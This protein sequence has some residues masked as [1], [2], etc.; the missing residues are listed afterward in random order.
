M[1]ANAEI[2]APH[3]EP[4]LKQFQA[5]VKDVHGSKETVLAHAVSAVGASQIV[6]FFMP[7]RMLVQLTRMTDT[8]PAKLAAP[9]WSGPALDG[10]Y[11][12]KLKGDC[13]DPLGGAM[14]KLVYVAGKL[15]DD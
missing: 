9:M 11:P 6:Q 14:L 5:V 15:V 4:P 3:I 13:H 8:A 10:G 1:H 7:D 12:P 2:K